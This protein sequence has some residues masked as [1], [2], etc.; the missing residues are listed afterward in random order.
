MNRVISNQPTNRLICCGS[1]ILMA[2]L[3]TTTT[4][5][6]SS[7][8]VEKVLEGTAHRALFASSFDGDRGIAVGAAGEI[9]VTEDGGKTW[10]QEPAPT[11]LSLTATAINGPKR[12][13]AGIT[14][15]IFFDNGDGKWRP[16]ESGTQ[17]RMFGAS[18]DSKGNAIVVGAFGTMLRSTDGGKTWNDVAPDWMPIFA[19]SDQLTDDFAPSIYAV[20]INDRGVGLAVGELST[21][22]RTEDAGAT[23]HLALGGPVS[24]AERPPALFSTALRSDGVG[25][26][27]G[28]SGR[29]LQTPD[30]GKTWCEF[31]SG[32]EVNLLGVATQPGGKTLISGIRVMLSSQDE[33]RNWTRITGDEIDYAWY[34]GMSVAGNA[35][36]T[37]GQSGDILRVTQ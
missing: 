36:V 28:Q 15:I 18:I 33:G 3:V 30:F 14:G 22:L 27:V 2:L 13:A 4:T 10:K 35:F 23:W 12:L 19:G 7:A 20:A 34:S 8:D 25:Y 9:Q 24:G 29:I 32:V 16:S 6:Q 37:V 21:I 26:A 5:V 11:Q 31:N 17:E 1:L